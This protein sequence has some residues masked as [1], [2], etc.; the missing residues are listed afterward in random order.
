MVE[1]ERDNNPFIDFPHFLMLNE[2]RVPHRAPVDPQRRVQGIEEVWQPGGFRVRDGHDEVLRDHNYLQVKK[3]VI[4]FQ[5]GG[6]WA[7][8]ALPPPIVVRNDREQRNVWL[9]WIIDLAFFYSGRL[10]MEVLSC[11]LVR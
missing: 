1:A 3:K 2:R 8:P 5:I 6:D 4:H 7:D 11:A 10:W 9:F